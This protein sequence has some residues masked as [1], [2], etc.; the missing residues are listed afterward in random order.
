MKTN[1]VLI[2]M[3]GSGKTSIGKQ[4]SHQLGLPFRDIDLFIEQTTQQ[5]IPEL[6]EVSEAHFR[7]IETEACKRLAAKETHTIISCGGGVILNPENIHALSQTGWIVFI[8]RPVKHIIEDI[9][10]GHRPLLKE[11]KN[12]LYQLY[13]ERIDLYQSAADFR[14]E[15]QSTLED[16]LNKIKEHMPETIDPKKEKMK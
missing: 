13:E 16:V 5:T 11:G 12:K 14:V 9:E 15:N 7:A 3:T 6:F 10:I 8:D 4:L 2:G 1:L